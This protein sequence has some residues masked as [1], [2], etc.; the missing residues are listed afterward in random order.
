MERKKPKKK[1]FFFTWKREGNEEERKVKFPALR[2]G[3]VKGEW[4]VKRDRRLR[5]SAGRLESLSKKLKDRNMEEKPAKMV[6]ERERAFAHFDLVAIFRQTSRIADFDDYYYI[7]ICYSA[8]LFLKFFFINFILYIIIV[9][10]CNDGRCGHRRPVPEHLTPFFMLT[11]SLLRVLKWV[12]I[13][14]INP[15]NR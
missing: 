1:V 2:G 5:S 9:L 13:G 10:V 7:V 15:F 14:K 4:N 6:T 3:A 8:F 11:I 12:S